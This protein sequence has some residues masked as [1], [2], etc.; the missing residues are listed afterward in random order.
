MEVRD[1]G[2][3]NHFFKVI[4]LEEQVR[5]THRVG[6]VEQ[7]VQAGTTQV[8]VNEEH[9]GA[10]LGEDGREVENGG[11]LA[12]AGATADDRDRVRVLIFAAEEKVGAQD[13]ISFGV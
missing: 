10:V 3:L 5:Q 11:G 2:G 12:F 9:L 13:A 6:N 7:L 4:L 8:G 1:L